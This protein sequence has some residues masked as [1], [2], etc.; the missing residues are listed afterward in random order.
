ML[1]TDAKPEVIALLK[2]VV[3]RTLAA[4]LASPGD[5]CEGDELIVDT[6]GDE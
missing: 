2:G 5:G 4:G 3:A 6:S 1:L